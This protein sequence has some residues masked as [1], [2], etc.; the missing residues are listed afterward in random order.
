MTRAKI[1]L[2]PPLVLENAATPS[3]AVDEAP[4]APAPKRLDRKGKKLIAGHFP[5]ATWAEFRNLCTQ[6]DKKAQE[7]LEEA[8]TD[9][10]AKYRT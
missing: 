2:K 6:Q 4:V 7:L 9:L 3:P 10:F 8:L 5:R 1:Q